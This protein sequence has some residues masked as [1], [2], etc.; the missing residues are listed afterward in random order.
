MA[1]SYRQFAHYW[2]T[3]P[4]PSKI[5]QF[6]CWMDWDIPCKPIVT[7]SMNNGIN[8]YL[9]SAPRLAGWLW[10]KVLTE[11]TAIDDVAR[12]KIRTTMIARFIG[13]TWG[14]SGAVRTRVGPMLAPWTLLSGNTQF[15][16]LHTIHIC[17]TQRIVN[18]QQT[19]LSVTKFVQWNVHISH[20]RRMVWLKPYENMVS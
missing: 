1:F 14:P 2:Y 19:M 11:K 20:T 15:I 18:T 7:F 3:E 10:E 16:R 6:L 13:P 9:I 4:S 17:L 12:E 8:I 5:M